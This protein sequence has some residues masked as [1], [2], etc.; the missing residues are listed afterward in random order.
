MHAK[1]GQTTMNLSPAFRPIQIPGK[2]KQIRRECSSRSPRAFDSLVALLA[3]GAS[4]I[5]TLTFVI[6]LWMQ[7]PSISHASSQMRVEN[8][9]RALASR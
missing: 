7:M 4:I 9:I 8:L 3:V 1:S 2:H 6:V 5:T